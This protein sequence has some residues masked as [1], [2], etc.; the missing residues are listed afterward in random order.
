MEITDFAKADSKGD[1]QN[2]LQFPL[3]FE[4]SEM[5]LNSLWPETR[6]NGVGESDSQGP[7]RM[8]PHDYANLTELS[9]EFSKN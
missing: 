1:R 2:K 7:W 8:T 3:F 9:F 6:S 4:F 5:S